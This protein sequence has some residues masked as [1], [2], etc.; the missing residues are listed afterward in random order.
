M[1]G[2]MKAGSPSSTGVGTLRSLPVPLAVGP[3]LDA[4]QGLATALVRRHAR[5]GVHG[6]PSPDTVLL[7][8]EGHLTLLDRPGLPPHLA[9]YAAPGQSGRLTP[10]VDRR[11]DPSVAAVLHF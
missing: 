10:S 11:A 2:Q 8:A 9:R 3:L 6:G 5:A 4:A 1:H 7:D